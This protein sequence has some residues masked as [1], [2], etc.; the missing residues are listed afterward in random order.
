MEVISAAIIGAL[1]AAA[2]IAVQ[3]FLDW[4]TDT[5]LSFLKRK[6]TS[7]V[8]VKRVI[9][10]SDPIVPELAE[11]YGRLFDDDETNYSIDD[12]MEIADS[13]YPESRHTKVENFT[14]V[15]THNS[16]P[17]GLCFIHYY[18]ERKKAIISY[19]GV[20][21]N[22]DPRRSGETLKIMVDYVLKVCAKTEWDYL[23]FDLQQFRD[24]VAPDERRRRRARRTLF[25]NL[26]RR[27]NFYPKEFLFNY[28][29][30]NLDLYK[31]GSGY[32][33]K[34]CCVDRFDNL[35]TSI[36]K[37]ELLDFLEFIYLDCYGDMYPTADLRWKD[38][39]AHLSSLVEHYR[40][41]LPDR[42][43]VSSS[44]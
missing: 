38:H 17:I 41:N 4:P 22:L 11:L 12:I 33:F 26:I 39:H 25:F 7:R 32:P 40:A 8:K 6:F 18:E 44:S 31:E 43:Q 1:A 34:L 13:V 19:I 30:P 23:F 2:I 10:K 14:I 3:K 27:Y 21:K 37:F 20:D 29:L 16:N 35:T 9:S 5:F 36:S 28:I 42:I 15:A 24:D